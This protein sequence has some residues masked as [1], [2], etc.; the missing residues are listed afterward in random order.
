QNLRAHAQYTMVGVSLSSAFRCDLHRSRGISREP[1][2]HADAALRQPAAAGPALFRAATVSIGVV[3]TSE[4]DAAMR[5]A[6]ETLLLLITLAI[7]VAATPAATRDVLYPDFE[8]QWRNPTAG[9]GGN[10]W[11][12]TKP[13]GLGQ[14]A[15]LTPEYQA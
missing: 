7:M 5:K 1:G 12:P 13:M 10:P 14:R 4:K 15:P 8:S 3:P 2:W 6:S 9:R 11:D